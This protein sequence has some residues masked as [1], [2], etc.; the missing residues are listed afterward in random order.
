M[1]TVRPASAILIVPFTVRSEVGG[2]D[3]HAGDGE[4]ATVSTVTL[5]AAAA[6]LC[7]PVVSVTFAVIACVA[8]VSGPVWMSTKPL[9]IFAI[10]RPG[11]PS[12]S[13]RSPQFCAAEVRS[14][15][16]PVPPS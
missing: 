1:D 2:V 13:P 8:S 12:P 11:L 14:V 9:A 4:R 6:V 7:A 3:D 15:A 5:I 16:V 10:V